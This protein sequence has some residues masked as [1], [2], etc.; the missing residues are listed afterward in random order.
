MLTSDNIYDIQSGPRSGG[1]IRAKIIPAGDP[2]K[3]IKEKKKKAK[4]S[5]K[6][7]KKEPK[8]EKKR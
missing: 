1:A 7:R 3:K 2:R 8:K 6:K 4:K 5:E